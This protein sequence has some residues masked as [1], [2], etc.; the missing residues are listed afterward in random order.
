MGFQYSSKNMS[1]S[2]K[3]GRFR[4]VWGTTPI[5]SICNNSKAE[6]LLG[7]ES[8]TLVFS[9]YFITDRFNYNFEKFCKNKLAKILARVLVFPWAL[10]KYDAFH[11]FCDRG[12]LPTRGWNGIN[13]IELFILRLFQKKIFVYTYGADVRTRKR[14]EALGRYNCCMHCTSVGTACICDESKHIKNLAK[15]RK[16]ATE[17]FSMG[18]MT[19]YTPGS[20]NDL[21]FW[22]IDVNKIEYVGTRAENRRPIKIV[23]APNHRQYK[24]TDYFIQAVKSLQ[25]EGLPLELVLVEKMSNADA[26]NIYKKADIIAEQFLIGWHGFMAIE[27]MALGKPVICYIRK[28][29]YLLAPE[30][31]PIISARLDDLREVIRDLVENPLKRKQL[32]EQ[33]REYVEKYFSLDA[34]AQRLQRVY[35]ELE[36][37][38]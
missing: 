11:F 28:R 34:F 3:G 26:I 38:R 12:I 15:I 35:D 7:I 33:G 16:Y 37:N 22:P 23:H 6:S 24:G 19:E 14:T 10:F 13:L 32:G 2:G 5:L 31:C 9:S 36:M 4:S 21:F 27:G 29:E 17:L 1:N 25:G 18:D 8:D 20:R 30:E